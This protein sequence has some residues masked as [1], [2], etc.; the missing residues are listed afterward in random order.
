MKRIILASGSSIRA[1]ILRNAGISFIVKKPDIDEKKIKLRSEKEGLDTEKTALA[2]SREK[3]MKIARI[4]KDT[5]IAADQILEFEGCLHDKPSSSGEVR[6]RLLEMSGKSHA[7][8]NAVSVAVN[9]QICWNHAGRVVLHMRTVTGEEIDR[10][11]FCAGKGILSSV[12]GYQLER[13]GSRLFD[14]IE[15]DHYAALGLDLYPLLSFL[16]RKKVIA[17]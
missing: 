10:Y 15:G 17:F 12:G 11:L 8:V 1:D 16:R 3:C 13:L 7:L 4:H 2:L 6:R 5:V 9:G 14:R